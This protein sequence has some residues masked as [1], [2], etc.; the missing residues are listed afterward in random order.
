MYCHSFNQLPAEH[1]IGSNI[2]KTAI[3]MAGNKLQHDQNRT[4]TPKHDLT[5]QNEEVT[6]QPSQEEMKGMSIHSYNRI[7]T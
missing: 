4:T 2:L 7:I 1:Q 6:E 3:V 5:E